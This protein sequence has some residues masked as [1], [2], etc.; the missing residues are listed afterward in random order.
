MMTIGGLQWVGDNWLVSDKWWRC[1]ARRRE[2]GADT[3]LK[4]KTPHVNVGNKMVP[5]VPKGVV[6]EC[7][8]CLSYKLAHS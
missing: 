2:G 5:P 4:T 8:F 6:I 7:V 3:R 1:G